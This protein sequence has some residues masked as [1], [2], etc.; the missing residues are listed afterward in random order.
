MAAPA[1]ARARGFKWR[2]DIATFFNN[3]ASHDRASNSAAILKARGELPVNQ[4]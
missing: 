1:K 4:R 2:E 3:V